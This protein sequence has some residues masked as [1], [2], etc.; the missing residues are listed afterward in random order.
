MTLAPSIQ[1][2]RTGVRVHA[3]TV[4]T[5]VGVKSQAVNVAGDIGHI[6]IS[7]TGLN[8]RPPLRVYDDVARGISLSQPPAF[9]DDDILVTGFLHAV[10]GE[11][12]GL[13]LNNLGI[14]DIGET[15]PRIPAH[16]RGAEA[17]GCGQEK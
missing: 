4:T 10:R 16:R 17:R 2:L 1:V 13:L 11:G 15:I 8:G 12:L 3:A 9:V 14:D 6:A 7:L 5:G